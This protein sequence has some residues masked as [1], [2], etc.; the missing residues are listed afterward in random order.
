MEIRVE[1]MDFETIAEWPRNPKDH[2]LPAIQKSFNRFGFIKPILVDE[3]TKQLVAGHG[4]LDSL[5]SLRNGNKDAP[6]GIK[7]VESQWLV[8]VLR[9]V[10]F[11]DPKEAEAFLLADNR[12]SEV[13]GWNK[14]LLD[15]MLAEMT[16]AEELLEGTGF[17]LA[18]I[19][20]LEDLGEIPGVGSGSKGS[21]ISC[22]KCGFEWVK[23]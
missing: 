13:G 18:D 14:D 5:R 11:D 8:P 6:R 10:E 17:S 12:L 7:I 19:P 4:R 20:D 21:F 9:G 23:K 2:D 1:Y 3:G 16:G 15:E 22:P